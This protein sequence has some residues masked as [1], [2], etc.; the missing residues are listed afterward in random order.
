MRRTGTIIDGHQHFWLRST[1]LY[2]WLP[3]GDPVLD[4]DYGPA[5]IEPHL[6]AHGVDGTILVQA[7]DREEELAELLRLAGEV[8]WIRGIVAPLE[9]DRPGTS[10]RIADYAGAPLVVG[11]RPQLQAVLGTDGGVRPEAE[12]ALRMI[13]E[14]GLALDCLVREGQLKG[15]AE[16]ARRYPSLRLV[17]DH[18]G[19]PD[20][21]GGSMD[22]QW[23][24]GI[25]SAA[26]E[27]NVFCK[28]S[29]LLTRPGA[30]E[31]LPLLEDHMRAILDAFGPGRLIWGSDWPVLN[32]ASAYG[33][34]LDRCL[35]VFHHL[36]AA[37]Q[38]AI[39]GGTALS[40]YRSKPRTP[41]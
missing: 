27:A 16:L 32:Q 11:F 19:N 7:C 4:R 38:A 40:V 31:N 33:R 9:L 26:A 1:G 5:D 29:G 20:F 8:P 13:Q 18:A 17:L 12:P 21:E 39:F 41:C 28:V 35:E 10:K 36:P 34:W 37:E 14:C 6:R 24:S 23:R 22:V 3:P 30:G 25:R 2:G 15:V